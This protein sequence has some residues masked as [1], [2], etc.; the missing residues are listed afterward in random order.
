MCIGVVT[1]LMNTFNNFY[2]W[3]L[4]NNAC[5]FKVTLRDF[6]QNGIPST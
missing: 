6:M 1:M 3:I 4:M 2:T 5:Y